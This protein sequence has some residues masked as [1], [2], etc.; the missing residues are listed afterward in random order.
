MLKKTFVKYE[1]EKYHRNTPD[2]ELLGDL[3]RV[4]KLLNKNSVTIDEYNENGEFHATTLSRRFGSWFRALEKANLE[5]TRT[6][7]VTDE[8]YFK[9]IEDVWIK[10]GRQP[11]YTEMEKPLSKYCV[12]SYEKRFGGWRNSLE[13]FIEFINDEKSDIIILN[14]ESVYKPIG[15]H[16]TKRSISWRL[17]FIVMKRDNF[18]CQICGSSPSKDPEVVLHVDHIVPWS[19]GGETVANNLQTLCSK[20]NI[21]KSDLDF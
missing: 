14:D 20:C 15:Q 8:E 3:I 7:G 21:G 11:R 2:E 17:R 5:K 6:L 10:L 9:N 16:R 18:K 19:K 1:L 4:S 13:K 12:G